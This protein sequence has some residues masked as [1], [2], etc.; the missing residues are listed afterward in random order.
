MEKTTYEPSNNSLT[1]K[2]FFQRTRNQCFTIL[3]NVFQ[4]TLGKIKIQIIVIESTSI[5]RHD[6][7]IYTEKIQ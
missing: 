4:S 7:Y 2:L 6:E 5:E 3:A 1:E